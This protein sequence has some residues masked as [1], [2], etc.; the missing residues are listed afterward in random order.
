ML[1]KPVVK[2]QDVSI[3][4]VFTSAINN[5]VVSQSGPFVSQIVY[6][7]F[8]T[9]YIPEHIDIVLSL[10]HS[11]AECFQ[12]KTFIHQGEKVTLQTYT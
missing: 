11:A 2:T 7:S 8:L 9:E 1:I 6:K 5:R 3:F 10:Q 12:S 4:Y